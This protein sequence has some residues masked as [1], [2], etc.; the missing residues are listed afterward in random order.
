[1]ECALTCFHSTL[2]IISAPGALLSVIGGR[3]SD[4]YCKKS[5][6]NGEN[7]ENYLVFRRAFSAR[8]AEQ[9]LRRSCAFSPNNEQD[10]AEEISICGPC[11]NCR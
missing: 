4:M 2:S 1:M 7:S 6:A 11:Q 5:E 9:M 8:D 10:V 3:S